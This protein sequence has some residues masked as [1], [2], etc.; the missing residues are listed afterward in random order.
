ME[1]DLI[2]CMLLNHETLISFSQDPPPLIILCTFFFLAFLATGNNDV[3][4]A[5]SV[6]LQYD[7]N[8]SQCIFD[9]FIRKCDPG[10]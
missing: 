9:D 2:G 10:F 3:S 1:P 8:D 7:L 5:I 4:N 6:V